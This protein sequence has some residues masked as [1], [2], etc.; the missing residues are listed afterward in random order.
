MDA[1]SRR[2]LTDNGTEVENSDLLGDRIWELSLEY[3]RYINDCEFATTCRNRSL[4]LN[5]GLAYLINMYPIVIGFN[6]CLIRSMAK[7]DHVRQSELIR[8]LAAQLSEEQIHNTMW[9]RKME[10]YGLDHEK[11]YSNLVEYLDRFDRDELDRMTNEMVEVARQDITNVAP[12]IFPDPVVPEPIIGLYHLLY[13]TATDPEID[14]WEHFACQ[15]ALENII[16]EVVSESVHPGIKDNPLFDLGP[17]TTRWW[18]EHARQGSEDGRRTD[19]EK[20]L[21]L[22]RR[23][24]N[25]ES[26]ANAISEKIYDRTK[27]AVSLFAASAICNNTG[28]SDFDI[29]PYISH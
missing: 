9:R 3:A 13:Q 27:S 28:K 22:S 29:K 18:T 1:V 24:L 16:F 25:R 23:A 21:Q 17:A 19:E 5:R 11:L 20:H 15:S 26:A 10:A 12:G 6:R 7:V 2:A 14:F 4:P 8:H